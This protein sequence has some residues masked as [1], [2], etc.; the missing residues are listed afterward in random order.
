MISMLSFSREY[1]R[2]FVVDFYEEAKL[3]VQLGSI[4]NVSRA[5]SLQGLP[6]SQ[7]TQVANADRDVS[8]FNPDH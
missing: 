7:L 8:I 1:V 4:E 3:L 6:A 5:K 2:L